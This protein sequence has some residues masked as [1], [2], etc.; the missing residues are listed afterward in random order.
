M[1]FHLCF[2]QHA[3]SMLGLEKAKRQLTRCTGRP[4]SSRVGPRPK[5]WAA[6][7]TSP[8]ALTSVVLST[9]TVLLILLNRCQRSRKHNLLQRLP[10]SVDSMVAKLPASIRR[11]SLGDK[12]LSK[13]GLRSYA[14]ISMAEVALDTAQVA[15]THLPHTTYRPSASLPHHMGLHL[16]IIAHQ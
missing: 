9:L 3:V 5:L 2:R 7:R 16:A 1:Y 11:T 14:R 13:H 8:S 6:S 15:A 12:R 4:S 10:V